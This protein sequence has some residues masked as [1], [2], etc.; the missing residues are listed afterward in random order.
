MSKNIELQKP[1]YQ[2]RVWDAWWQNWVAIPSDLMPFEDA[3]RLALKWADD[4]KSAEVQVYHVTR[5]YGLVLMGFCEY[6][7]E[8]VHYTDN[9]CNPDNGFIFKE[10][11]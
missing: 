6:D 4:W 2:V 7:P 8:N 11:L 5:Y 1:E 3:V 9:Y 10:V